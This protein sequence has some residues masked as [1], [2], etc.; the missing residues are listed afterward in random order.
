MKTK[1]QY[2]LE[3]NRPSRSSGQ[4]GF[5]LIELHIAAVI[6]LVGIVAV[7]QLVPAAMKSNLQNRVDTTSVVLAQRELDQMT[8]QPLSNSTF[9]DADGNVCN[10][11]NSAT[12]SVVVGSPLASY[13]NFVKINFNAAKVAGYNFVAFAN[14]QNPTEGAYDVRWAVITQTSG[15]G[16]TVSKRFVIGVQRKTGTVVLPAVSLDAW[17]QLVQ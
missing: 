9:T 6:F 4:R 3:C 1:A 16:T 10:L 15:V 7:M 8:A 5:T 14:P 11:G 13:G 2:P 12:P 17:Q